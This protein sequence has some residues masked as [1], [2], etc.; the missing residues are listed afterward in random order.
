MILSNKFIDLNN[1]AHEAHLLNDNKK[2]IRL[3][4]RLIRMEP[5]CFMP[6]AIMGVA[7]MQIGQK[8]RGYAWWRKALTIEPTQP[9]EFFVRSGVR[10]AN[11]D[12][13][14][15]AWEDYEY[16]WKSTIFESKYVEIDAKPWQG[17]DLNGKHLIVFT[18]QGLGDLINYSC[19]L[20]GLW[21]RGAKLSLLV[22]PALLR[23][24]ET[25]FPHVKMIAWLKDIPKGDYKIPIMSIPMY[26]GIDSPDALPKRSPYIYTDPGLDALWSDR[27]GQHGYKIGIVWQG[28]PTVTVDAGRSVPL[29]AFRG[30]AGIAGVRLISLQRNYGL[31]QLEGID[32]QVET[33]DHDPRF[34]GWYQT[35]AMM[36]SCDL[37]IGTC[38]SVSHMAGAIAKKAFLMLKAVPDWRWLFETNKTKWYPNTTIFRQVKRGE[39]SP[40]F[41]QMKDAINAEVAATGRNSDNYR[42][43]VSRLGHASSSEV[44]GPG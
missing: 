10:L 13:S 39:W 12:W 41:Q 38:T 31:E 27:I 4:E 16:R 19:F 18:E 11:G 34:D 3:C 44:L 28:N 17:E 23:M 5:R 37:V 36:Q 7:Y 29:N 25:A 6:Y 15:S 35:A 32:F 24:F 42:D 14:K 8:E 1:E 33:F 30:I 43:T 40:V 20:E 26:L 22:P 9:N 21:R 2:A